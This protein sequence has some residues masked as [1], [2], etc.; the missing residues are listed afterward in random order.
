MDVLFHRGKA[1]VEDIRSALPDP[2]TAAAVR[3]MMIRLEHKGHLKRR[4]GGGRNVY[5][6]TTSPAQAR[7]S[8]VD[9]LI[10][11]FFDGSPA[12]MMASILDQRAAELTDED[13]RRIQDMIDVE[14]RREG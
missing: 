4:Q 12:K 6:P 2:P 10:R 1:T 5:V 11:T 14:R 9:R 7:R 13:L 3:T 8:A